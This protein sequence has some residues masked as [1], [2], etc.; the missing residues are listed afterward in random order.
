M[1]S[2]AETLVVLIGPPCT[3]KTRLAL[4]HA[5]NHARIC[6][7]G[8]T[9]S[10]LAVL[11]KVCKNV[12][13]QIKD[14]KRVCLDDQHVSARDSLLRQLSSKWQLSKGLAVYCEPE[15]G[16]AQVVW[17]NEWHLAEASVAAGAAPHADYLPLA[18]TKSCGDAAY[19]ERHARCLEPWFPAASAVVARPPAEHELEGEGFGRVVSQRRLPLRPELHGSF[20]AAGLVFD[21]EVVLEDRRQSGGGVEPIPGAAEAISAYLR[22]SPGARVVLLVQPTRLFRVVQAD[23]GLNEQALSKD[24]ERLEAAVEEGARALAAQVTGP[25]PGCSLHYVWV[26]P[27]AKHGEPP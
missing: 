9:G 17:A 13:R 14:G 20:G 21:A 3:G 18:Q 24:A 23:V 5:T 22:T 11:S 7:E 26:P 10:F 27:V 19:G 4:G 6:M 1:D 25:T 12:G 8:D 15:G 2:W 16:R